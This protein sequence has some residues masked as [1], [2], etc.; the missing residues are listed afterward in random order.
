[1]TKKARFIAAALLAAVFCCYGCGVKAPPLRAK[2]LLPNNVTGKAYK[3]SEDG[4]LVVTFRPPVRNVK[5]APLKDLGGFFVDRGEERLSPD[6]CAG[7][8]VTYTKRFRIKALKPRS[9]SYVSD[10]TYELE[11]ILTPGN[12]Y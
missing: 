7:C 6:F 8:P 12:V 3:F 10:V 2:L 5:G 1:M 11:D 9:R 4:R